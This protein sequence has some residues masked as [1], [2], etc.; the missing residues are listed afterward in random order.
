MLTT[1]C[2]TDGCQDPATIT[3]FC[4]KHYHYNKTK[5][6]RRANR[7]KYLESGRRSDAKRR[8]DPKRRAYQQQEWAR[9]SKDPAAKARRLETLR[10]YARKRHLAEKQATPK[11]ADLAQIEKIYAECPPGM[12]VDHVVPILGKNVCGLHVPWNLQYLTPEE[13][14]KKRNHF[15]Y[16]SGKSH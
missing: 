11:W 3:Q 4:K 8:K 9:R 16:E 12:E 14:A 1:T 10:R 7:E 15:P 13:N 5:E 2:Q 6:W